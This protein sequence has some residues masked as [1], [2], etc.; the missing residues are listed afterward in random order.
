MPIILVLYLIFQILIVSYN[1][2]KGVTTI[3]I[4]CFLVIIITPLTYLW[5]LTS[6]I[7]PSDSVQVSHREFLA[8]PTIS[9]FTPSKFKYFCN[10]CKTCIS[11]RSFHCNKCNRCVEY[12]DHHCRW[13][14]NCIGSKNYVEFVELIS[15]CEIFLV[16]SIIMNGYMAA[17]IDGN[18]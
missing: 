1:T 14:N 11:Q 9:N 5:H 7:D 15:V 17:E 4:S 10:L 13:L 12:F 18:E 3:V 16:F 8:C 2:Q 6:T